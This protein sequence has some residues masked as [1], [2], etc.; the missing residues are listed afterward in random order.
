MM[1]IKATETIIVPMQKPMPNSTPDTNISIGLQQIDGPRLSGIDPNHEDCVLAV[2]LTGNGYRR[3]RI[4]LAGR[5]RRIAGSEP[6]GGI[7][8]STVIRGVLGAKVD[9]KVAVAKSVG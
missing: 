5:I 8:E 9:G 6:Y 4:R 3:K 2:E 7:W 1:A